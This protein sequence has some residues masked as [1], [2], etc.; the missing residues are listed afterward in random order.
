MGPPQHP[1]SRLPANAGI[2]DRNAVAQLA[3]L[4]RDLL[5][6]GVQ[7]TFNHEANDGDIARQAL[8]ENRAPYLFLVFVLL[9]GIGMAAIH[10][11]HRVKAGLMQL[12]TRRGDMVR[13]VIRSMSTQ[14]SVIDTP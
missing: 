3:Q 14:A 5:V 6:P 13:V 12:T 10:H 1:L 11:E 2:G 7:I 9:A 8:L 4:V